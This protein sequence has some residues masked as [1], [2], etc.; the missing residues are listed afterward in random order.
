MTTQCDDDGNV[1]CLLTPG[2]ANVRCTPSTPAPPRKRR[3]PNQD[4]QQRL[5][6]CEELLQEYATAKPPSTTPQPANPDGSETWKS[7]GKL[8]NDDNGVR[9]MDSFLWASV[10]DEVSTWPLP[11]SPHV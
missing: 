1:V 2:Q 5:A 6:R 4:L 9:F 8:V 3:R 11:L 10:H 7:V